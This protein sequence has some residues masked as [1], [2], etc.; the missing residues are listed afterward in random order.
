[1]SYN[2]DFEV[3]KGVKA[4]V[5]GEGGLC[6]ITLECVES[7]F[8]HDE[9]LESQKNLNKAEK[10]AVSIHQ[11]AQNSQFNNSR[12]KNRNSTNLYRS[13]ETDFIEKVEQ[14]KNQRQGT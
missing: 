12:L 11:S 1:M 13:S 5:G 2:F 8:T 3:K 6:L 10:K 14:E 4:N 9:M 7:A